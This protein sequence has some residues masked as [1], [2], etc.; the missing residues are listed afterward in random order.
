MTEQEPKQFVQNQEISPLAK[1]PSYGERVYDFTFKALTNFWL[2]LSLSAMFS[3]W[4]AHSNN[5]VKLPFTN[6]EGIVPRDIQ[7][8]V[9]SWIEKQGIM[10][11]ISDPVVRME[12]AQSMGATLTL[13]TPGHFI[14]IPS[15]WLA[16]KI[17]AP[18]VKFFNR[19]HYGEEAM[20]DPMLQQRHRMIEQEARP[21]LFGAIVGRAGSVVATQV[22][23][24]TVGTPNNWANIVGEKTNIGFLKKFPG[25]DPLAERIGELAGDDVQRIAPKMTGRINQYFQDRNYSWSYKQIR[26]PLMNTAA[27]YKRSLQDFSRYAGQDVLYTIITS[28]S[29]HPILNAVSRF[30]PGL[31]YKPKVAEPLSPEQLSQMRIRHNPIA[32]DAAT[33]T[34]QPRHENTPHIKV[35]EVKHIKRMSQKPQQE[36]SPE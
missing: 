1:D 11:S 20:D 26:D 33:V 6:G 24:R 7:R 2:N 21:T 25:M 35:S 32:R 34:E 13:L 16:P 5:R 30:I 22:V 36:H 14:L 9:G 17:K 28:T 29:V 3:F 31:T 23:A 12:R 27:P 8:T 10:K 18:F 4:V 19:R 15:V